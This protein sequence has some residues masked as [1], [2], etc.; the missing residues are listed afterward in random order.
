MRTSK[1]TI[2]ILLLLA[3]TLQASFATAKVLSTEEM[4]A[5]F[6]EQTSKNAPWPQEQLQV[7]SFAA[8]PA[9]LIIPEG[10]IEYRLLNQQ[11]PKYLGRKVV[12]LAVL[13]NGKQAGIIKMFGDL[14]LYGKIACTSRSIS[15]HEKLT[16]KDIK[17]I[18][19]DITMLGDDLV[20]QQS[21]AIGKQIT[22]SLQPGAIIRESHLEDPPLIM[23]G[24]LVT[25]V[26][27]TPNLR[28]TAPGKAKRTGAQGEII[29]VKNLMSRKYIFAK[30]IAN[31]VVQVEF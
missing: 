11:H 25:I 13:V 6:H 12:K 18:R 24:D 1:L 26:A 30:V 19:R 7:D 10:K 17:M 15:R 29:R 31:G 23:R 9:S 8:Q 2:M 5:I 4:Q 21:Q 3:S 14:H 28:A 20:R 22:T 27:K 16:A